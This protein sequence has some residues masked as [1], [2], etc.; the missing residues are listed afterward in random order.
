MFPLRQLQ[1]MRLSNHEVE[2]AIEWIKDGDISPPFRQQLDNFIVRN[3]K[4]IYEPLNLE[5]VKPRDRIRVMTE[6]YDDVTSAGK[7]QNNWYRYLT[8][9]NYLFLKIG[10]YLSKNKIN[11]S[12]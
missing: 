5:Y 9:S 2:E 6:L 4:L 1:Q 11:I 3:D 8:Y 7:G 10:T 12:H